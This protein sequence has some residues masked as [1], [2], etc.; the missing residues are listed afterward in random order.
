M[1]I[2]G[3]MTYAWADAITLADAGDFA[4][5]SRLILR[6][7]PIPSE[8]RQIVANFIAGARK[9]R[10]PR[11]KRPR[12][13]SYQ[14]QWARDMFDAVSGERGVE[15][16]AAESFA[17]LRADETY[18]LIGQALR[19]SEETARDAVRRRKTYARRKS[20]EK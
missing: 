9:P 14:A 10:K 2:L 6:G 1:L 8:Y 12:L 20:G 18:A 13:T 15:A 3:D 19:V 5:L 16:R 11:G 17:A 4:A 7:E